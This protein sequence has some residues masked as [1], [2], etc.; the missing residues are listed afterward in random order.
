MSQEERKRATLI[1]VMS[2]WRKM[3]DRLYH[4]NALAF[5]S[6]LC[7]DYDVIFLM[8]TLVLAGASGHTIF[9]KWALGRSNCYWLHVQSSMPRMGKDSVSH[10]LS[11]KRAIVMK[12]VVMF[13]RTTSTL[14]KPPFFLQ[15]AVWPWIAFFEAGS[16]NLTWVLAPS[17]VLLTW[18]SHCSSEN[19]DM[20]GQPSACRIVESLR[21][22][23][24]G[25]GLRTKCL[26]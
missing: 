8:E 11:L 23:S 20:H 17:L 2:Y 26:G 9:F 15:C 16:N 12:E 13:L 1:H 24:C 10:F 18:L 22:P 14:W 4:L 25:E 3:V 19:P 5:W 7:C 6:E 21:C